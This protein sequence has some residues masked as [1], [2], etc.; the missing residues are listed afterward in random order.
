MLLE[1]NKEKKHSEEHLGP[2]REYWWNDDYLELLANRLYI[3]YTQT[4]VDIGCGKGMMGFKF[5]KYLPDGATVY[6]VDYEP[7]YIAEAQQR[8]QSIYGH[9]HINYAFKVGNATDI[10]L[11]DNIADLTLCQTL[12]IHV[13]NPQRV[14]DEMIRVTKPG[15]WVLALE[16]NNL[17]PNLMFDRYGET[18]FDVESTLDVLEIKLRIEKGKKNLGEGFN[19]LGDVLPDLYLKA[20]LLDT[21]VWISDKALAIIPPY[22]TQEKMLRVEQMLQWVETEAMGYDYQDNLNYYMAGGGTKEKFDAYWQKLLY[23]K[24]MLKQKLQNEEYVSAGG[25]LVYIVAGRKPR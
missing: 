8:A 5:S 14:I 12:L 15:G 7:G 4:L 24:I 10:P 20:G 11:P 6:G 17:V 19:S 9:N 18:D 22:D 1:D 25:S 2:A 21:K 23:N 16:P 3:P 13:K